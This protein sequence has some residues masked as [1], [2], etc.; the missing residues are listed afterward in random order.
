MLV[1]RS[2]RLEVSENHARRNFS[3]TL[4]LACQYTAIVRQQKVES[5]RDENQAA[6]IQVS[7]K[8]NSSN[9]E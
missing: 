9:L 4:K 7:S 8:R 3:L 1:V 6:F 5:E 2:A